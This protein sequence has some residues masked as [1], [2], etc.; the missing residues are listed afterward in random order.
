V[1]RAKVNEIELFNRENEKL[2]NI[3][4]VKGYEQINS[5]YDVVNTFKGKVIYL[6]V[7]GTW[8]GPCKKELLYG[9]ELKQHFKDKDIVFVY[10]DMDED[11]R[12]ADW[13]KFIRLNSITGLHLRKNRKDIG[14]F[15]D[16]LL[17]AGH[18]RLYPSYFV[19][20][21]TGKLMQAD[22]KRPSDGAALYAELERYL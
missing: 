14:K 5:I 11:D 12:D 16:E 20:D 6:D 13:K 2:K 1:L 3:N 15:W 19:F 17:P 9:P 7:W 8:C 22:T 10:L 21:K 4:V 18:E